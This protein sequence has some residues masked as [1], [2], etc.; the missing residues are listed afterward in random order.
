MPV[1]GKAINYPSDHVVSRHR[2]PTAQLI[3]AIQGVMVVSTDAG[4]W[5]VPPTRG[6]WMPAK[7]PHQIRTVGEV[8]VRTVY[9]RPDASPRLPDQCQVVGV[10][11][12][13][14]ELILAALEVSPT[15]CPGLPGRALDATAGGRARRHSQPPLHLPQPRDRDLLTIWDALA[16]TPDDPSILTEWAARPGALTPAPSNAASPN[17]PA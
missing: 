6:L 17:R 10:S 3:H 8:Q 5:V 13:L 15:L 14:R 16:D 9:I 7:R 12:L 11:P 1:T 4:Q 2:H